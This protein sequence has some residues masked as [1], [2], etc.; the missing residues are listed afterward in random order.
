[1]LKFNCYT[2]S[3]TKDFY[4]DIIRVREQDQFLSSGFGYLPN[5]Y[6]KVFDGFCTWLE[7]GE[8]INA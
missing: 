3:M 6:E 4:L 7:N 5:E 2:E 1:M 8:L